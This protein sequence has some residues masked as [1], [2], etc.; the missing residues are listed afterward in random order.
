MYTEHAPNLG[1]VL[2]GRLP[3]YA[4]DATFVLKT[5]PMRERM[6]PD[7]LRPR[8]NRA[9]ATPRSRSKIDRNHFPPGSPGYL[10]L[11]ATWNA[12]APGHRPTCQS[13]R[14]TSPHAPGAR[15]TE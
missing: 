10:V 9:M 14:A 8:I 15:S 1:N 7:D 13:I 3:R 6:S 4:G 12:I 5:F 2:S 11:Q